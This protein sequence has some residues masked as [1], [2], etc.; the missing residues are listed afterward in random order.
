M[1]Q[2]TRN[3]QKIGEFELTEK[4]IWANTRIKISIKPNKQEIKLGSFDGFLIFF[5]EIIRKK[6]C[7]VGL[8]GL[9]KKNKQSTFW[10][11]KGNSLTEEEDSYSKSPNTNFESLEKIFQ[12][13]GF[14]KRGIPSVILLLLLIVRF[15][16]LVLCGCIMCCIAWGDVPIR[17]RAPCFFSNSQ[18]RTCNQVW[19]LKG[20][21]HKGKSHRNLQ[22]RN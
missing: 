8:W 9:W 15:S 1:T 19:G 21:G 12:S 20:K 6:T 4:K 16:G 14:L 2:S 5:V 10:Q 3:H 18:E 7:V 17:A 11:V 13:G 22:N